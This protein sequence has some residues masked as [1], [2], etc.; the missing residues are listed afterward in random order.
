L[1]VTLKLLSR[2]TDN[3]R[4]AAQEVVA[5]FLADDWVDVRAEQVERSG[6]RWEV[7]CTAMPDGVIRPRKKLGPTYGS[8]EHRRMQLLNSARYLA[9]RTNPQGMMTQ[10]S[11]VVTNAVRLREA[12]RREREGGAD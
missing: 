7:T 12:E 4:E 10:L 9:D 2:E 3:A 8:V 11:R 5:K 6:T 1:R